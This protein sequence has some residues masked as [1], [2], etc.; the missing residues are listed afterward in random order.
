MLK[1]FQSIPPVPIASFLFVTGIQGTRP[2][3][4]LYSQQIGVG[5]EELGILVA[6][7]ALIPLLLASVA[8]SLMDRHGMGRAL[9]LGGLAGAIGLLLPFIAPGRAGLY[10]SQLI[11]GTGFTVFMLAAQNQS[12]KSAGDGWSRE[13]AVAVFSMGVALGSFVGPFIGGI[14]GEHVGYDRAFLLLGLPALAAVGFVLPQM[15]ADRLETRPATEGAAGP[16]TLG[17]PLRV[18]GYHRYML[19]AIM[20]SSLILMGKDLFVAYFPLYALSAGLSASS[21]GIIIALHNGGGVVMRYFM[22]PLVRILGKDRVIVLSIGFGGLGFLVLPLFSS[23]VALTLIALAI[24]LGLGVGQPLS[25][26]RTMNL[27]PPDKI[28]QVLGF[29][30]ACNRFTQLVTPLAVSGVVLFTGVSG[31]FVLIGL[32]MS[33]GST[34]ISIPEGEERPA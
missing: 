34:R 1:H 26:T 15:R 27:S 14:V 33:I 10:V 20:V 16:R 5:P 21:I 17:N 9:V 2:L 30:L 13:R 8:G 4:P 18:L 29:R 6:V 11:A 32:V 31:V 3:I 24:G 12:G 28:G 7:F 25:I 19:R 22:L 23:P